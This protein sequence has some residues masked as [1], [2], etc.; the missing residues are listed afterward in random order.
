M[1]KSGEL[2]DEWYH[3]VGCALFESPTTCSLHVPL[4][5][6]G[7]RSDVVN[8]LLDMGWD[9]I[10]LGRNIMS[11]RDVLPDEELSDE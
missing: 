4:P 11:P 1:W 9:M 10:L 6:S 7:T 8:V 2:S 3:M 5:E